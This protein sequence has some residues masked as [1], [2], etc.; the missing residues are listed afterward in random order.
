MNCSV[1]KL[2]HKQRIRK[3]VRTTDKRLI[4]KERYLSYKISGSIV[5]SQNSFSRVSLHKKVMSK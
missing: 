4:V 3:Y 1:E 2:M 5:N